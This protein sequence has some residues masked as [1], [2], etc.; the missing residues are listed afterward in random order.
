MGA[1]ILAGTQGWSYPAWVGPFY[2]VGTRSIDL[3]GV[4][5]R[6]FQSVEVDATFYAIPAEPVVQG[7][8]DRVPD[9]FVFSLKVPQEIT[10]ERRLV[11]AD[12][13]LHRFLER[14]RLLGPKLGALL[15]QMAPDWA[16]TPATRE[17]LAAFCRMLPPEYHWAIEFRDPKWLT[18]ATL[19]LLGEHNVALT[20]VDG[21]WMRRE[22]MIQLGS[23][24]T[25][26]FGYVRWMGGDRRI[27]DYSRVQLDRDTE[28]NMWSVG[29]AALHARVKTIFGYF[30]NR[31]QGHSPQSA[32][33]FQRM[34]GQEP[35]E[36][37]M[38][39]EQV[40]LF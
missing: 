39:Q 2:P 36:P 38:L 11:D 26:D 10:H 17:A 1:T 30:N 9:D 23:R 15:L 6:A 31:F 40:E 28:L 14:V 3:L 25:A 4:Y 29:I 5:A 20:L 27:T 13:V 16:P 34:I 18:P 24:P 7:W 12:D 22:V 8:R 33:D 19:E 21:R 37:K 35:V 32:R